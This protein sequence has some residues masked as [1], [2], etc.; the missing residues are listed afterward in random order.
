V[1]FQIQ[2]GSPVPAS[3]QLYSQISFAIASRFYPPGHRLPSTRQ[4]AM[5]TNLHRNTVSKV[6]RQLEAHGI[7]EAV[8]GSGIYVRCQTTSSLNNQSDGHGATDMGPGPEP[9]EEVEGSINS[10]LRCG[11]TLQEAQRQLTAEINWRINCGTQLLV[12]TPQEDFGAAHLMARELMDLPAPVTALPLENLEGHLAALGQAGKKATVATSRY[13]LKPVGEVARAHKMRCL[14]LDLAPLT[15]ELNLVGQLRAGSCV[16]LVSLSPGIL[17][18]A[19]LILQA[20][21]G[22][23][24]LVMTAVVDLDNPHQERNQLLNLCRAS[25]KLL[26]DQPSHAVVQATIRQHRSQMV[27]VPTLHCI[28]HYLRPETVDVLSKEMGLGKGTP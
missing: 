10:L 16:G 25:G 9:M 20:Q 12:T 27:R 2:A 3:L 8:A 17:R 4:L 23:D 7:V 22:Q 1:R 5:Q 15:H 18:A 21:R 6:Y 14:A 11:L 19:E 28:S 26:C 24:L 13:F